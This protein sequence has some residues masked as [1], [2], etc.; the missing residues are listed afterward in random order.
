MFIKCVQI[1]IRVAARNKNKRKI[2]T[3]SQCLQSVGYE[4]T[5]VHSL[6]LISAEHD[7]FKTFLSDTNIYC[8]CPVCQNV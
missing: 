8:G 3:S 5:T 6:C 7:V 4:P 2:M 1:H